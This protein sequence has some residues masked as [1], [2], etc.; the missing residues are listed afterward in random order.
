MNSAGAAVAPVIHHE[1]M[2][3]LNRM[4]EALKDVK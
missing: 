1:A 4:H 3:L 2:A